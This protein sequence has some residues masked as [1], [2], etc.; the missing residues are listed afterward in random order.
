[1]DPSLLFEILRGNVSA[2][3]LEIHGKPRGNP[4]LTFLRG[5]FPTD[6]SFWFC[7]NSQAAS[8]SA[9]GP[10]RRLWFCRG[11]SKATS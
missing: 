2:R 10:S 5:L 1:M 9:L 3:V 4:I 7:T 8:A 11:G 6:T